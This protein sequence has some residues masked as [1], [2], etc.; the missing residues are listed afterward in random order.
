MEGDEAA[1]LR[2]IDAAPGDDAPRLIYADW[3]DENGRAEVAGFIRSAL[4]AGGHGVHGYWHSMSP[5]NRF[6]AHRAVMRWMVATR[7]SRV[8]VAVAVRHAPAALRGL[9]LAAA[10]AEA[11][12]SAFSGPWWLVTLRYG[13]GRYATPPA[14]AQV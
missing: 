1:L 11:D 8:A 10:D 12:C 14:P 13:K 6:M 4:A 5:E 3:C 2:G 9:H 7:D